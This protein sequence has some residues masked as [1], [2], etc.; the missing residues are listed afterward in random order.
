MK[1]IKGFEIINDEVLEYGLNKKDKK[2]YY[3][4]LIDNYKLILNQM[5]KNKQNNIKNKIELLRKLLK[6]SR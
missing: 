6:E 4:Y 2:D 5:P 1:Y 3:N